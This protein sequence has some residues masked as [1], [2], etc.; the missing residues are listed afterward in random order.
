MTIGPVNVSALRGFCRS[1]AC[2]IIFLAAMAALA[3]GGCSSSKEASSSRFPAPAE[4]PKPAE[5]EPAEIPSTRSTFDYLVQNE[6]CRCEE[7]TTSDRKYPVGYRFRAS[8][9]MEEGFITSISVRIENR[10]TD[11]L[12][13][14]PGSVMVASKN[15]DYQYNNKFIPLPDMVI[16]PGESQDLDLDGKEVTAAPSWRKIAGEQ[17]TLTLKGMRLGEKTLAKQVV[18]F[19]PENPML[20]DGD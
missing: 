18:T 7:Y 9:R 5:P 3:A 2:R 1:N 8:Y 20:R 19:V 15:V 10:G 16:P 4:T 17:L 11:T 6:E 12:F 14:D 13:L